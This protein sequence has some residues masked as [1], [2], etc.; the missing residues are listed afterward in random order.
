MLYFPLARSNSTFGDLR[1]RGAAGRRISIGLAFFLS[2]L[3]ATMVSAQSISLSNLVHTYD[4]SPKA[5]VVTTN[6]A[7]LA[8]TITYAGSPTSPVNAGSYA[9]LATI[10]D[11]VG[12]GSASG[13]LVIGK[14]AQSINFP[15][16]PNK[17]RTD[18]P[19]T[20]GA[21]ATSGLSVTYSSSNTAVATVSGNTVTI[22]GFGTTTITANQAGNSNYNAALK[23]ES[24]LR[25]GIQTVKFGESLPV[26]KKYG[27]PPFP[28]GATA[29]SGL[30]V[31]LR[32]SDPTVARISGNIVTIVGA[33]QCSII[34]EQI[35]NAD[36]GYASLAKPLTIS[37]GDLPLPPVTLQQ[38]YDGSP[39]GIDATTLPSGTAAQ[40]RYRS[41]NLPEPAPVPQIAFQNGPDTLALSYSSIGLEANR[42]S[43]LGKLIGLAGTARKLHSCDVTLVTWAAYVHPTNPYYTFQGWANANPS[44]VVPPS[45]GVSIPGNSGGWYHP[46]TL[47]FYDH[48]EETKTWRCLAEKTV[49]AFIPWL[50]LKLANGSNYPHQSHAFRVTFEFPDGVIL[51]D[52]V[53]VSVGFNTTTMGAQP[54]GSFGPYDTLNIPN[55][56]NVLAGTD[57]YINNIYY[58]KAW[59]W[60]APRA[61]GG[62]MLRLR[63]VPTNETLL[64]PAEPG[65]YEVKTVFTGKGVAGAAT[66]ALTIGYDFAG[67]KAR[68]ISLGRLPADQSGDTEDP[69]KD[70]LTN[71]L[72]YAQGLHPGQPD[73]VPGH[74]A[75]LSIAPPHLAF[76]YRRNLQA[77]DLTYS[78]EGSPDLADPASWDPVEPLEESI[79]SD[80]GGTR[81]LEVTVPKPSDAEAY[82]LRLKVSR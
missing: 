39:K 52:D 71:L 41:V 65:T 3:S 45:P 37:L 72:E 30:P 54:I 53:F 13:A 64:A 70:G 27:D 19:F 33:G 10:V 2:I 51:P 80:D 56:E 43:A 63:T 59:D 12:S 11:P 78:I 81:V 36:Y 79:L 44:L 7:G 58:E 23:V 26:G 49:Q 1:F 66:T 9:V 42:Y 8:H 16:I 40:L 77:V 35:G 31:I 15:A 75:K 60:F 25:V 61:T 46:I 67:W 24:T 17:L 50:P 28:I 18:A 82:F 57:Y 32:S 38:V 34:A 74:P 73:I 14:A 48:D 4:G 68:E 62:P 29:S 76:T 20:L 6:P 69:D 55:P 5:A 47:T 22:R 21:T